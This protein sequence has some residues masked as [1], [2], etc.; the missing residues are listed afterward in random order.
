MKKKLWVSLLCM[1][2]VSLLLNNLFAQQ[3]TERRRMRMP[4]REGPPIGTIVKD[5]ELRS[6]DGSTFRLSDFRGKKI[7]VLEFGAST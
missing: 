6:T 4:H 5:F 7:V 1:M 2:F 3:K